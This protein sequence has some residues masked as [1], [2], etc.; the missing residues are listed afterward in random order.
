M[1]WIKLNSRPRPRFAAI[2]MCA[3]ALAALSLLSAKLLSAPAE[4]E[5][6]ITVFGPQGRFNL[7]TIASPNGEYVN[8]VAALAQCGS[9]ASS[10]DGAKLKLRF[11]GISALFEDGKRKIGRASCREG[12]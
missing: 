8:L 5:N 4:S 12:G 9:V 10:R 3:V 7:K 2:A 6:H 11:G 1:R